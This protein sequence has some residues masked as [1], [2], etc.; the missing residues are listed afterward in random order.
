M[1][2]RLSAS[3]IKNGGLPNISG[4]FKTVFHDG[5]W[6]NIASGVFA[7]QGTPPN[8]NIGGGGYLKDYTIGFVASRSSAVYDSG[9][10]VRPA[11]VY[12]NWC[13]KF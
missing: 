12:T 2:K 8:S 7:P 11:A 5:Q 3:S 1:Q 10:T 9:I 13:I 4:T 6:N